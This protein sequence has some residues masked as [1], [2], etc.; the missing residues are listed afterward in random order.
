[1]KGTNLVY[2]KMVPIVVEVVDY[3]LPSL[4]LF[5]DPCSIPVLYIAAAG[6]QCLGLVD[7]GLAYLRNVASRC[8]FCCHSP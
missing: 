3:M 5:G 4:R 7:I 6:D 8:S 1:M 2:Y